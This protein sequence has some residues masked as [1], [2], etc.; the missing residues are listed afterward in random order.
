MASEEHDPLW[1]DIRKATMPAF[2]ARLF[3]ERA[4]L[5]PA[6]AV[7][8]WEQYVLSG[9][10]ASAIAAGWS[11]D[12]VVRAREA[13]LP[14]GDAIDFGQRTGLDPADV[15]SWWQQG[16]RAD[17]AVEALARGWS[18]NEA[19]QRH[20]SVVERIERTE[21]ERRAAEARRARAE[22]ESRRVGE[23]QRAR[24]EADRAQRQRRKSVV[25]GLDL[26]VDVGGSPVRFWI[27]VSEP[28]Y[29]AV[30]ID[31]AERSELGE[32][33]SLE[34]CLASV[35]ERV[36][37]IGG[38]I[39]E[40]SC[41]RIGPEQFLA[42][43]DGVARLCDWL[44]HIRVERGERQRPSEMQHAAANELDDIYDDDGIDRSEATHEKFPPGARLLVA[45]RFSVDDHAMLAPA[46]PEAWPSFIRHSDPVVSVGDLFLVRDVTGEGWEPVGRFDD[47]ARG[48]AA[49]EQLL[50]GRDV[51]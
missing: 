42:A 27:A 24:D 29:W 11:L 1:S 38:T 8:W 37:H 49:A 4:G 9:E 47:P 5:Q 3:L 23:A 14:I 45:R 32:S 16:V 36:S 40:A 30:E 48:V 39:R 17:E 41:K 51:E 10:A 22:A 43:S 33:D 35:A 6:E 7:R 2:D 25:D 19:V 13:S 12:D 20:P 18:L 31:D 21:A 28:T 15:L 46:L 34:A 50:A 26:H 44:V